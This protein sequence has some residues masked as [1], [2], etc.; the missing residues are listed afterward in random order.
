MPDTHRNRL[1]TTVSAVASSGT[2]QFTISSASSGFRTFD[3]NDDGK[4]FSCLFIEGTDWEVA[5]GC[6]YA[7][8]GGSSPTLSRGT[9]ENSSNSNNAVTFTSAAIVSVIAPASFGN[10][11]V[12]TGNATTSAVAQTLGAM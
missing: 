12:A 4:T 9:L 5:T 7:H 2:G 8:N 10:E 1:Q 11:T 3:S 6:T